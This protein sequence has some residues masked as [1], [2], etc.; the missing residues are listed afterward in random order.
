MSLKS[1]TWFEKC[2]FNMDLIKMHILKSI[3]TKKLLKKKKHYKCPICGN[4]LAVE[5]ISKHSS[6]YK[7]MKDQNDD[8]EC[9]FVFCY[10]CP[11][12]TYIVNTNKEPAEAI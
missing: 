10:Y 3:E 12:H 6:I 11:F 4:K 7:M 8:A 9:C 5:K 1:K 2:L